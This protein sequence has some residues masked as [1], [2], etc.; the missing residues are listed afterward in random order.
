MTI[1]AGAA[2]VEIVPPVPTPLGGYPPVRLFAGGPGDH[3]GYV[4]RT[5]PSDGVA[6]PIYA[7][8]VALKNNKQPVLLIGL[9]VCIVSLPFA[10]AAK[11]A[12]AARTGVP[13]DR[14]VITAS[15]SHSAPDYLGYWEECDPSVESFMLDRIVD[16]AEQ[17][18]AQLEPA[19]VGLVEGSLA[20]PIVNRRDPSR[21][22]DPA[23]T[24]LAIDKPNQDPIAAVFIYACHPVLIGAMNRKV[25]GDFPGYAS[26][27]VEDVLGEGFVGLFLNGA[28]GN[29]N[30]FAY[31]YSERQNMTVLSRE[32]NLAGKPVT[33]R[34]HRDARRLGIA[35]AG[36]VLKAVEVAE[37]S[38]QA[39]VNAWRE[40]VPIELKEGRALEEYFEHLCVEPASQKR[41]RQPARTEVMAVKL[42]DLV[43]LA[44]PG[45]PFVEIGLDLQNTKPASR[46]RV[47]AIGYANDYPGYVLRPED[48][49]ENRY[50]TTAT[51][52]T[53][54]GAK[55]IV[56]SARRLRDLAIGE[57]KLSS[58]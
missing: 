6:L 44:M 47:R 10:G 28:A 41:W 53:V 23:V 54:D 50:E 56:D 24:V 39:E 13:T 17:A 19:R 51:P 15:H 33:F 45:E 1:M 37:P 49:K 8:A 7:R 42:G 36:E 26:R 20:A 22:V 57:L 21:P 5:G 30:P 18:V 43:V 31:P 55:A 11:D 4:G 14:I 34:S 35:L 46:T 2:R 12:I 29:I 27:T 9:E 3:R 58:K 32:Y 38:A 16:A 52:L 48:Y 25:S 40:T